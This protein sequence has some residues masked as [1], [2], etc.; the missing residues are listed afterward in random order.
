MKSAKSSRLREIASEVGSKGYLARAQERAARRKSPWNLLD[1]P[2]GLASMGLVWWASVHAIWAA[3][4]LFIPHHAIPF[5]F[6]FHS[7]H[8]GLAPI[9]FF[10]APLIAVIPVG[11]LVS[12]CIVW[13]IPS[14]RRASDREAKGVWHASF[15]DAQRDLS[16]MAL[17]ISCP[18][19]IA[20]FVAALVIRV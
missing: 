20:S 7:Q 8:T 12:N 9:V 17:C 19:L 1:L 11:L 13:C 5:S 14:Y 3:R 10:V 18:A 6:V 4:N 16:L 15:S 2:V